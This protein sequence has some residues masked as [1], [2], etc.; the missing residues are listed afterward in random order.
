[1]PDLHDEHGETLRADDPVM[2]HGRVQCG[3]KN[4][5]L[6]AGV[7]NDLQQLLLGDGHFAL[8][9]NLVLIELLVES[10]SKFRW[11]ARCYCHK[12]NLGIYRH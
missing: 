12:K 11:W 3:N 2:L 5:R 6:A 4:T 10:R 1:M 9:K 7:W 8:Q